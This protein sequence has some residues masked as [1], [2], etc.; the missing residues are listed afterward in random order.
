MALAAASLSIKKMTPVLPD[1]YSA[2]AVP[3]SAKTV[4]QFAPLLEAAWVKLS[5]FGDI[6]ASHGMVP[7]TAEPNVMGWV[8]SDLVDDAETSTHSCGCWEFKLGYNS[9]F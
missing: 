9:G 2:I 4:G 5:Y 7:T 6:S 1:C 8:H 3:S